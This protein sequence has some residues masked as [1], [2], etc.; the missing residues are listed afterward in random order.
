MESVRNSAIH[1]SFDR[2]EE[3]RGLSDKIFG[4]V[5]AGFWLVL[6]LRPLLS[7]REPRLWALLLA[8]LFL[9]IAALR[10]QLLHPFNRLWARVG[11]LLQRLTNPL[12]MGL[13]FVAAFIPTA[14]IMRLLRRDPLQVRWDSHAKSYWITRDP[15]GPSPQS[16]REQF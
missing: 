10:P 2:G 1:E 13:L 15:P 7:R 16:M 11:R 6:G 3:V 14:L 8:G 12:I 5:L 9:F 4:L